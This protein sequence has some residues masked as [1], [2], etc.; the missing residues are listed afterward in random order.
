MLAK[1][2]QST[3]SSHKYKVPEYQVGSEVWINETLFTD[4]YSKSQEPLKLSSK[5]VGPFIITKLI[6]KNAVRLDPPDHLKTHP[7]VHVLYTTPY[8]EPEDL[9]QPLISRPEPIPTAHVE[10]NIVDKIFA[11][12]RRGRGNQFLTLL[13]GEPDH[14]AT[15]QPTRDFVDGDRT[16]TGVWYE[17][18]VHNNILSEYHRDIKFK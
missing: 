7:I 15:W 13:R 8:V 17:Y 2:R 14:D 12:R 18:I 5:R 11:H 1:S 3:E 4:L 10:E 16:V 9:S 6:G